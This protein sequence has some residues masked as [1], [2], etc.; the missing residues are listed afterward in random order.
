MLQYTLSTIKNK[1]LFYH[2]T[3]ELKSFKKPEA[4][5]LIPLKLI[6]FTH[7]SGEQNINKNYL[8]LRECTKFSKLLSKRR[9][10]AELQSI[11]GNMERVAKLLQQC[12]WK[13]KN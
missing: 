12:I 3:L 13:T 10:N 8:D 1:Y 2:F 9:V 5:I 11:Y 4:I 7:T 6:F